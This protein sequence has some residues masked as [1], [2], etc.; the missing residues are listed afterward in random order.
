MEYF[1]DPKNKIQAD[2]AYR[3]GMIAQQY[4]TLS[5]AEEENFS[6][7]LDICIL[8]NLLTYCV[9]LLNAMGRHERPACCLKKDLA[10]ESLW[11]LNSGMI[12]TNT[13]NGKTTG[14]VVLRHIR[15]ALCHPTD[16]DLKGNFP[17]TGYTTITDGS[18]MIREY[19]FVSSP[20]TRGNRPKRF[21]DTTAARSYLERCMSQGD[22]PI[23]VTIIPSE[24]QFCL[25]RDGQ[26]FARIFQIQL[27]SKEIHEVVLGLS[28]Y[29]AQPIQGDWDGITIR[30]LIA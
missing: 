24:N 16:L 10:I 25:G 5:V 30:S 22:M 7:T 18:G 1:R 29:L 20:D 3:L 14:D 21:S 23:D 13:F 27:T 8:Q 15:N 6:C 28:N 11:G 4:S 19:C 9:S 2:M 12:K 26:P 17:S